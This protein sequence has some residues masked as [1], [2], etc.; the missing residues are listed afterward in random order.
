MV[1]LGRGRSFFLTCQKT[2]VR[3]CSDR[4]DNWSSRGREA[5]VY[6]SS[7][8]SSWSRITRVAIECGRVEPSYS[9]STRSYSTNARS[10]L[11]QLDLL[12]RLTR[13]LLDCFSTA[14]DHFSIVS[15]PYTSNIKTIAKI[16]GSGNI[17]GFIGRIK[18]KFQSLLPFDIPDM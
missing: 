2:R 17:S 9:S 8:R 12:S 13:P 11:D 6:R 18:L 4:V 1:E 10:L 3:S 14:H 16:H 5:I 7:R 15:R